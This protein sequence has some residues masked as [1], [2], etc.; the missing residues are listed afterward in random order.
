MATICLGPFPSE[1]HL[2]PRKQRECPYPSGGPLLHSLGNFP[3]IDPLCP[4]TCPIQSMEF[5][6]PEYWSGKPFP[7]PGDLPNPGLLHCRW[8]LLPTELPGKPPRDGTESTPVAT[9]THTKI[10]QHKERRGED[11][12]AQ[13]SLTVDTSAFIL[14]PLGV[15][16]A[17][18]AVGLH[19]YPHNSLAS[20]LQHIRCVRYRMVT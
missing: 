10:Q 2:F 19:I 15:W 7:S 11:P 4:G 5:C 3:M 14:L 20:C 13:A 17:K 1:I 12:P 6:R 9:L 18:A 8:I 16:T